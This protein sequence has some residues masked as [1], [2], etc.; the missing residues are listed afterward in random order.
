VRVSGASSADEAHALALKRRVTHIIIPSWDSFLDEYARLGANQPENSLIG[1][2]HRWLAPRWLRPIPYQV[3]KVP[4]FEGQSAIVFEVVDVQEN[5]V[6]LSHLA[7]YFVETDQLDQAAAVGR[8]LEKFF[9]DDLSAMVARAQVD[10]ARADADDFG[11]RLDELS[12]FLDRG[13]D[14]T[15]AWDRRVSLA[16][17]L[18]E[19]KRFELAKQQAHRCVEEID[20]ARL[21]S[22]TTVSLYRFQA[23]IKG[24]GLKV[25]NPQLREL[26]RTLLPVE[27]RRPL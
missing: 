22:L 25:E 6:A 3:P 23:L 27:M 19:G 13:D 26:S 4:G 20:E 24:F 2:L 15:L 5:A 14:E 1:L 8:A 21:R 11:K 18:A 12:P 17:V 16:V 10:I 9:P 7:E